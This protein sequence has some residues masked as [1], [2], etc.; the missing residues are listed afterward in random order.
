MS[1]QDNADLLTF[2][3]GA[4]GYHGAPVNVQEV[5]RTRDGHCPN[6]MHFPDQSC[7]RMLRAG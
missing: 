4:W 7:L 2:I 1:D 3:R 6:A 5:V